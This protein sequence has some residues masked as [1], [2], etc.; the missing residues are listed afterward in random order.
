VAG[1]AWW[2]GLAAA[3]ATISCGGREHPLR[4]AAG[5]LHAPAHADVEG[6]QILVALGGRCPCVDALQAWTAHA[7]DLHVLVL[8]SRGPADPVALRAE[9]RPGRGRSHGM[10]MRSVHG[11]A[12]P[13]EPEDEMSVLLGLGG[14][15]Q[16]RLTATVAAAWR[17]RLREGDTAALAARPA[18]HAA[19]YGRVTAALRSWTG[20][21]DLRVGLTMI[22]EGQQ[23]SLAGLGEE[24]AAELPFGWIVDVWARGLSTVWGRFCLSASPAS[25]GP[26]GWVVSAVGPDLGPPRP[27]MLPEPP[28]D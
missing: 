13:D 23:P 24:I 11:G 5:R 28:A 10:I 21:P 25:P 17:R 1:E 19:L 20:R 27:I 9:P 6:E 7:D 3:Q 2:R 26:D 4:W 14:P 12:A 18:L 15:L 16:D 22:D 8:A